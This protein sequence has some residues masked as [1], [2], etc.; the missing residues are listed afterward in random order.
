MMSLFLFILILSST[1][2]LSD[3]TRQGSS[4]SPHRWSAQW[5]KPPWG[6]EPGIE[7]EPAL[8]IHNGLSV[9]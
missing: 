1:M 2:H 4:P 3:A 9:Q 8:H 6:A 7:L 5:E